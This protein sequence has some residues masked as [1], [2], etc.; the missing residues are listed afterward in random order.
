MD[1]SGALRDKRKKDPVTSFQFRL[2]F[3]ALPHLF[4]PFQEPNTSKNDCS[5][6]NTGQECGTSV[7]VPCSLLPVERRRFPTDSE[8]PEGS[9]LFCA[10][11]IHS[12]D[13]FEQPRDKYW[14][15][16]TLYPILFSSL[17]GLSPPGALHRKFTPSTALRQLAQARLTTPHCTAEQEAWP[18]YLW[19]IAVEHGTSR[20]QRSEASTSSPSPLFR[21]TMAFGSQTRSS[22]QPELD[23]EGPACKK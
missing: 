14:E 9:C 17:P 6:G 11:S 5:T 20:R 10:G 7:H 13:Y 4:I 23:R 15:G 18:T 8:G 21:Q 22:K 19:G 12:F 2:P 1:I 16:G 3:F